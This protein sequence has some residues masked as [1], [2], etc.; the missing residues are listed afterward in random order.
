MTNIIAKSVTDPK[1]ISDLL[2]KNIPSYRQAYS[3]RT[4]WFM[5][6]LSELAY[7]KFNPLFQTNDHKKWFI[8]AVKKLVDDNKIS[9]LQKL[10]ST[11]GYD[12]NQEKEQL[13]KE[14]AALGMQLEDTFD[15]DGTQAILVSNDKF[16]AL[17]FR[18][19]EATSIKDIKADVKAKT[20]QCEKGGKIHSG[21][22]D[23]FDAVAIDVQTKIN[24]AEYR[25]KPLFITGHSLGGALATIAAKKLS[26][27]GGIAACYTFGSPRVGNDEWI[28]DIK[29][30]IYRVVN[31][32]DC[33]TMLPPGDELVTAGAWLLRGIAWLRVWLI[34]RSAELLNRWL[35]SNFEGYLHG[36]DMRYMTNCKKGHY[37]EVKLLN[38]VSLFRRVKGLFVKKLPW[39]KFLSDHSISVYR[40]KLMIIAEKRNKAAI[41]H[42]NTAN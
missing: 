41:D 33:V 3:D 24:Q 18:G 11:V 29:V 5:A 6:C 34:S 23:A 42:R 4:A 20:T 1:R 8:E 25:D 37:K 9:S 26:R 32:A 16:I 7:I 35:L 10:I 30:P 27:K 39:K 31:A 17:A 28:A 38:H 12:H 15:N 2:D 40:K 22:N 13:K 14:L 21:F 36:G 19:T